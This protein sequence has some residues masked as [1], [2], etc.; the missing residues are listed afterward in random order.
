MKYFMCTDILITYSHPANQQGTNA[1]PTTPKKKKETTKT[2]AS[3]TQSKGNKIGWNSKALGTFLAA[4]LV[5][6]GIN[7]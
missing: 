5:L 4:K 6:I 3:A 1:K 7:N 2:T